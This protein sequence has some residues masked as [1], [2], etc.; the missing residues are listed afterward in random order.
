MNGWL[1]AWSTVCGSAL[2]L[3]SI[4]SANLKSS[5]N[6]ATSADSGRL[7][8]QVKFVFHAKATPDKV[9]PLMGAD[10][11]RV[12][13]RGWDPQFVYPQPAVDVQGMV[14]TTIHN[15]RQAMWVNTEFDVKTGRAQYVYMVPER[16]VTVITLKLIPEANH[17]RVEVQYD[18]TSLTPEADVAVQHFAEE[19]RK[20][21][22]EWE[23]QVN[24]YLEKAKLVK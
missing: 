17:T 11:E 9:A 2:A 14:F 21:G 13:A 22:A 20:A 19:D 7:H 6:A 8:T 5:A 23:E 18:R 4:A 10:K 24:A 1:L 16:M 12:W 3:M 15:G